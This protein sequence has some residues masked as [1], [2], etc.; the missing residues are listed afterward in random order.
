V[1]AQA[2]NLNCRCQ[3]TGSVFFHM[4]DAEYLGEFRPSAVETRTIVLRILNSIFLH[5]RKKSPHE[6]NI[7]IEL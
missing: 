4:F 2:A 3:P 5:L 6:K 7:P 1:Y